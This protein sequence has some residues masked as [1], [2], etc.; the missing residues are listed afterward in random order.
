MM[1]RNAE[2]E[3]E[4]RKE[5]I[6]E[7][8]EME[9]K[10]KRGCKGRKGKRMMRKGK[11]KAENLRWINEEGQYRKKEEEGNSYTVG[12]ESK[13]RWEREK[14]QI[15]SGISLGYK[16][17]YISEAQISKKTSNINWIRIS[18]RKTFVQIR[19]KLVSQIK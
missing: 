16:I 17:L 15:E 13:V 3:Q 14:G 6:R 10:V 7:E 2:E 8:I 9:R 5:K 18:K 11:R 1:A 4:R 12:E 19:K